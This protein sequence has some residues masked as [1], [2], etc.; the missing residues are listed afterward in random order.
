MDLSEKRSGKG[1]IVV[2]TAAFLVVFGI[3]LAGFGKA[4]RH[5]GPAP[6]VE[7]AFA[8]RIAE[9]LRVLLELGRENV[10]RTTWILEEL[11]GGDATAT[12][13]VPT[14]RTAEAPAYRQR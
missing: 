9:G 2:A 13:P 12:V 14:P 6:D 3:L 8:R 11:S 4:V 1:F 10:R 5:E 7:P